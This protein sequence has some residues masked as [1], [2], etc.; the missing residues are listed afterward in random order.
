MS[1][2]ASRISRLLLCAML[3]VVESAV[4]RT[5][6]WVDDNGTTN[7]SQSRPA[8]RYTEELSVKRGQ[9]PATDVDDCDDL[10]CRV[11]RLESERR[12][13]E[14]IARQ[15]RDAAA[16]GA[17]APPTWP[18]PVEETDEEKI[19]RLVAECKNSRGSDCDS[20]EEKR[21]MLLQNVE[22]SHAERRALRGFSPAVQRRILLQRI[23]RQ[24]REID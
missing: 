11:A 10:T 12:E 22:L 2:A 6:K 4:A 13:R 5:F 23:P 17:A 8:D 24:Y 7:Y 14:R 9:S 16:K 1:V 19:A 21:R 18:S 15:R 20:D 3:M